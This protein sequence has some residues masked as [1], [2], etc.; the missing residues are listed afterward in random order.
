LKLK[1]EPL[2]EEMTKI[3]RRFV[4]LFQ[5]LLPL[6]NSQ[7]CFNAVSVEHLQISCAFVSQNLIFAHPG[8]RTSSIDGGI[9]KR[10]YEAWHDD[11]VTVLKG[12]KFKFM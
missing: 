11:E 6:S 2:N 10:C 4:S 9:S 8:I 1:Q 7:V 12:Q 3:Y 5:N